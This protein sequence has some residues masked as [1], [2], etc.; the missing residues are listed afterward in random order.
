MRIVIVKKLLS[1][2]GGSEAQARALAAGLRDRDHDVRLVA[3]RPSW[4]R[5]GIPTGARGDRTIREDGLVYRYLATWFAPIDGLVG[6]SLIGWRRLARELAGADVVHCI[7]REWAQPAERAA[8][9][10]GA[11]FVE[12]P[13]VH[14][15]QPFS[16]EG[17]GDVRRY[18]RDDRV[19]VF[20]VLAH[21]KSSFQE[22]D[23]RV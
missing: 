11:A 3:L 2:V 9:S 21:L 1:T 23:Q 8:R 19:I 14:P 18:A 20:I 22:A 13:L 5:P 7:A 12:T 15:G 10:V 4:R 16:G 17:R 6:T